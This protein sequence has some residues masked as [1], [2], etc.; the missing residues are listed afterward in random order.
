MEN[1]E[2]WENVVSRD[3]LCLTRFS[4]PVKVVVGPQLKLIDGWEQFDKRLEICRRK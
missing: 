1:L 3:N 2:T 4:L